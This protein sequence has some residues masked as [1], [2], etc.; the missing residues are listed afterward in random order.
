MLSVTARAVSCN[1]S[2]RG[3]LSLGRGWHNARNANTYKHVNL[4]SLVGCH[5][6]QFQI[7]RCPLQ[8]YYRYVF[9]RHRHI[10]S[11]TEMLSVL[12]DV[13][14]RAIWPCVHS[15]YCMCRYLVLCAGRGLLH[16]ACTRSL[17]SSFFIPFLRYHRL[18]V[19]PQPGWYAIT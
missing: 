7:F 14:R 10:D 6:G 19:V 11:S 2:K 9:V 5:L 8:R 4:G 13:E 3:Y 15:N 1:T 16:T 18:G 12:E 17:E